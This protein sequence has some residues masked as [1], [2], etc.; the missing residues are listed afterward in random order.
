MAWRCFDELE[1]TYFH[2][3]ATNQFKLL[4]PKLEWGDFM[5]DP[6]T[7]QYGKAKVIIQPPELTKE[8][9]ERNLKNLEATLSSI[10]KAEVK[11]AYKK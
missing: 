3:K 6:I 5:K 4:N 8:E 7:Y 11:L 9:L 1:E 10:L 2:T